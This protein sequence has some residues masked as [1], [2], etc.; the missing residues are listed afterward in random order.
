MFKKAKLPPR[1]KK[2]DKSD[3]FTLDGSITVERNRIKVPRIGWLKTY[4]RLPTCIQ[5]K[6]VTISKRVSKWFISFKL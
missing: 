2:K 1:F 4:E 5:P 6:S 3:S